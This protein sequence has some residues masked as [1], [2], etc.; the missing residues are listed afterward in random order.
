MMMLD[1]WWNAAF[2]KGL[3]CRRRA[4]GA[5]KVGDESEWASGLEPPLDFGSERRDWMRWRTSVQTCLGCRMKWLR[6]DWENVYWGESNLGMSS[7]SPASA[8]ME[9]SMTVS[10]TK[11]QHLGRLLMILFFGLPGVG[12]N[13]DVD[14][15][16]CSAKEDMP[17]GML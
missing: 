16:S 2:C 14:V 11:V 3:F 7:K 17:K 13:V 6:V 8:R 12:G 5:V 1:I 10:P 9:R 4:S 15:D